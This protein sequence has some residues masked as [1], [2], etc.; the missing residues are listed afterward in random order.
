M[1]KQ[2]KRIK[3]VYSGELLFI[4]VVF[5]VIGILELLKVITLKDRFQL[6]FKIVTLAGATWILVDFLWTLFSGKKRAKNSLMDKIMLLPLAIYLYV[7]DIVGFVS[8]RPYEYYQVGIPLA[9]FYFSC[10]YI[11][12]AIYHYYHPIPMVIQMIEEAKKD[13]EE[14]Q[15]EQDRLNG[16]FSEEKEENN[17]SEEEEA[18]ND[19]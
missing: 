17:S 9:L 4:A 5:L 7:F 6:I 18:N 13:A 19:N 3:W 14:K 11:F 1:E 12:Q 8:E 10:A 2:I 16:V 15:M